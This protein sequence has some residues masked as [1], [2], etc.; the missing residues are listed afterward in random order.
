[1]RW[2]TRVPLRIMGTAIQ[3]RIAWRRSGSFRKRLM[4]AGDWVSEARS[5]DMGRGSLGISLPGPTM[6][7]GPVTAE[8]GETPRT[9]PL[10]P[11]P[12]AMRWYIFAHSRLLFCFV[13]LNWL[14]MCLRAVWIAQNEGDGKRVKATGN[15]DGKGEG[16]VSSGKPA[17]QSAKPPSEAPKQDYIHV[18]ARR[19]QATDSHS[20]AERV[21]F[22]SFVFFS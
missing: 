3:R 10:R 12:P 4:A 6:G 1:V 5:S 17:E 11:C 14:R 2:W 20:L 13:S 9:I 19:G 21:N 18:R 7:L 16:E 8:S 15:G 22:C